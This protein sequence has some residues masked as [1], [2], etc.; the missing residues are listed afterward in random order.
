MINS[1]MCPQNEFYRY[2]AFFLILLSTL[3]CSF[4]VTFSGYPEALEILTEWLV[5]CLEKMGI[6]L[7]VL[8]GFWGVYYLVGLFKIK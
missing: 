5:G 6:I 1:L 3:V 8:G 4:Y 7:A 2:L